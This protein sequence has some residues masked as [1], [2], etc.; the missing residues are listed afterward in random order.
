MKYRK[1]HN[2]KYELMSY[3]WCFVDIAGRIDTKYINLFQGELTIYKYYAWD[4][5]SGPT[6]DDKT[7][8]RASLFHDA[9]Y[10]LMREGHLDKSYRKYA[11]QLFRQM[12][13][14]AGMGKFRAWYYYTSVRVLGGGSLNKRNYPDSEIITI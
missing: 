1:L 4:G 8:M 6:I 11:D 14:E 10:Q 9:L 7:N 13:L 12:C 3:D 2:W 5:A